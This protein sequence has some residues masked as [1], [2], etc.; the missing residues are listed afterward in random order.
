MKK[1]TIKAIASIVGGLTV[2]TIAFFIFQS[3]PSTAEATMTRQEA[4][5]IAQEQFQGNVVSVELDDGRYEI[6][7]ETEDAH[8]ELKLDSETGEIIK[9]EEKRIRKNKQ[10]QV[11]QNT[12]AEEKSADTENKEEV[13][14]KN[15]DEAVT[16]TAKEEKKSEPKQETKPTE[17]KSEPKQETKPTEK[18]SEPKQETKPAEKKSEP[19]KETPKKNNVIISAE[20]AKEIAHAEVPNAKITDFELDSDDGRRYYEIEMYTDT[21]EVELEIDAYTGK[22]IMYEFE[23][24][25]N[26]TSISRDEAISIALARVNDSNAWIDE[27]ELDDGKYEIEIEGPGYE[28]EI[29]ISARTGQILEYDHEYDD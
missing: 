17:K 1:A 6:E 15:K 23:A 27:I 19:K 20:K 10:D 12:E 18:K 9:L 28:V 4:E 22:I 11:A 8:Y 14:E 2:F 29:E 26:K 13:T 21:Q 16:E 7:I 24:R 3:S 25:E 5:K